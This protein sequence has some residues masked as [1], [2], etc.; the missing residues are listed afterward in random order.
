MRC[1]RG[2][3]VCLAPCPPGLDTP[4]LVVWVLEVSQADSTYLAYGKG[5]PKMFRTGC[6]AQLRLV[7]AVSPP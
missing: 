5:G 3:Q 7:P 4:L 1:C 2:G 6:T